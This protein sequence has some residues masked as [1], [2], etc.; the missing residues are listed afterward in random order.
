[1]PGLLGHT[2]K[3]LLAWEPAHVGLPRALRDGFF[4]TSAVPG[5][6]TSAIL[7]VDLCNAYH[8]QPENAERSGAVRHAMGLGCAMHLCTVKLSD[9]VRHMPPLGMRRSPSQ[10]GSVYQGAGIP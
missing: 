9:T 5:S 10:A 8:G 4:Q 6:G 1:M 2:H 7:C 3:S